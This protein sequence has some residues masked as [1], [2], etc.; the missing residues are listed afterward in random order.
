MPEAER[1]ETLQAGKGERTPVRLAYRSGY[2]GRKL[3][4]RF[5]QLE[6]R[7]R[8]DRHRRFRSD[9]LERYQRGERAL[10]SDPAETYAQGVSTR[11]VNAITEHVCGGEFSVPTISHVNK[12][13]DKG[14][15]ESADQSQA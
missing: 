12:S 13:P 8:Q 4:T 1:D 11:K 14:I 6:L 3:V 9:V 15:A 7:V 10:A 2:Y 5:G